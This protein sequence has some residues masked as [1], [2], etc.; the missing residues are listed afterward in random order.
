MKKSQGVPGPYSAN[1]II[2]TKH[3]LDRLEDRKMSK[4]T[5]EHALTS[6]D[7]AQTG[8]QPGTFEYGKKS[9]KKYVTVIIKPDHDGKA[10]IVS[11]WIDPPEAGTQ[12]WKDKNYYVQYR[13]ARSIWGQLW[14]LLKQQIG[15]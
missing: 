15:I 8:K 3:A 5:I 9:G 14:V 10:I 2:W 13:R 11:C 12:D 4:H 6:P 7:Y 1:S